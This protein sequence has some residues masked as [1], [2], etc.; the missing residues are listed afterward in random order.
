MKSE[1]QDP[2]PGPGAAD[3]GP[4]AARGVTGVIL[5]GGQGRRMG[6]VDKGLELLDG[7]PMAQRVIERFAPQVEELLVNANRNVERYAHFGYRIVRDRIDGFAGPLAGLQR[8]LEEAAQPLVATAPCDSPFLPLDLVSRL[9]AALERDGAELAVARTGSQPHPVFCLC[10]KRLLGHLNAFL[11][12]G[13]RKIDAWYAA[14][15]V[16]EV[17]FDDEAGAFDNINTPEE[18]RAVQH[19]S[20]Q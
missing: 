18:L 11:Q 3:L 17:A 16:I 15:K 7:V 1:E 6:S 20:A 13:G 2:R 4:H 12:G 14:L 8:G 5:A 10:R 9:R 19:R